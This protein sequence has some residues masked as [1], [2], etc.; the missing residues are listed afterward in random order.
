MPLVPLD[1][2]NDPRLDAYRD[3]TDRTRLQAGGPFI[4]EGRLVVR[5]LVEGGRFRVQSLLLSPAAAEDAADLLDLRPDLS[6]FVLPAHNIEA[7]AGFH[8]H[9]GCLAAAER[10]TPLD[11]RDL[12][13]APGPVVV[14]EGVGDPDNVGS[15]FRHAAA[16]GVGAILLGPGTV[17]PLYRKAIRTSMGAAVHVPFA[18]LTPWPDVLAALTEH[19]RTIVALTLSPGSVPLRQAAHELHNVPAALL[20]GHEG[21]GLS[22]GAEAFAAVRARIP[23]TPGAD[24]LNVATAAAIALHEWSQAAG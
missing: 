19:G 13:R 4:A 6:A 20:L 1:S 23:M 16:F 10:G 11:W 7:V 12:V 3:L 22:A 2:P 21:S 24:S 14:L 8:V 9:R 17:D 5:R 15:I 18:S